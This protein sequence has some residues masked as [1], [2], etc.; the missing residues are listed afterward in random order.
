METPIDSEDEQTRDVF[1]HFGLAA[2]CAQVFEKGLCNLLVIHGMLTGKVVTLADFDAMEKKTHKKP[3]GAL[4][5]DVKPLIDFGEADVEG[6]LDEALAKRN[7]L[8]H[9]YFWERAVEFTST[10]GRAAMIAE[11][12]RWRLIFETATGF[13]D[14]LCDAARKARGISDECILAELEKARMRAADMDATAAH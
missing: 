9:H 1:A 12:D 4:L 3:L 5:K 2:Y 6:R 11:L 7:F 14:A 13:V 8:Q 10:N